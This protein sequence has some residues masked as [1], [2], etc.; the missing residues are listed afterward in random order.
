MNLF[1][2]NSFVLKFRHLSS[3][4]Y[5]AA[6]NISSKNGQTSISLTADL[7]ILPTPC[8]VP[9]PPS[10]ST[11][12]HSTACNDGSSR[13][14]GPAYKRR[15]ERRQLLQ[16]NQL[17]TQMDT[18]QVSE[19]TSYANGA[20]IMTEEVGKNIVNT[21]TTE[22][23]GKNIANTN[24][25]EEVTHIVEDNTTQE[26]EES[27]KS[28]NINLGAILRKSNFDYNSH[29]CLPYNREKIVITNARVSQEQVQYLSNTVNKVNAVLNPPTDLIKPLQGVI[30]SDC[31]QH[32]CRNDGD[33]P[34]DRK[35]CYHW[36]RLRV[37]RKI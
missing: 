14:K 10:K 2:L 36:C 11:P 8:P 12:S 24:T 28:S 35:C 18:E 5:N 26:D 15:Q 1:E 7:G 29:R 17:N 22:E 9:P 21:N 37:R 34:P 23:V 3:V 31:C 27:S 20:G 13:S 33:H 6:L 25:T 16:A 19:E 32:D 30:P 4:G